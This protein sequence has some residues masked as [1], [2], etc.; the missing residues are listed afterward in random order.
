MSLVKI[1]VYSFYLQ[2]KISFIK[3]MFKKQKFKRAVLISIQILVHFCSHV[4]KLGFYP[5]VS[6]DDCNL[7]AGEFIKL[8]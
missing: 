5:G 6:T 8:D 2:L 4:K 3:P 1:L 7:V